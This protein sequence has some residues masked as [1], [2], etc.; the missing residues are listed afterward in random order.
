MWD[1]D[2]YEDLEEF[3]GMR[4]RDDIDADH[5]SFPQAHK[6][7]I[8]YNSIDED[9]N[10]TLEVCIVSKRYGDYGE[11]RNWTASHNLIIEVSD[12]V[13]EEIGITDTV[14]GDEGLGDYDP[15][16]VFS[17][18]AYFEESVRFMRKLVVKE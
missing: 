12:F 14:D 2:L 3:I 9:G 4:I 8:N 6:G 18:K 17:E 16:E 10:G 15:S 5:I 7:Y 11:A 1:D 13:I